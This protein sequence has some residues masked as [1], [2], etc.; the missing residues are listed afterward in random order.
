[1]VCAGAAGGAQHT[2]SE[3]RVRDVGAAF[4]EAWKSRETDAT[5]TGRWDQPTDWSQPA[6]TRLVTS[7]I[8]FFLV[9][10][11]GNTS[12]SIYVVTLRQTRLVPG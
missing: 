3:R 1:M 6:S 2:E 7:S 9:W 4:T 5:E 12:V 10:L 11:S 8:S